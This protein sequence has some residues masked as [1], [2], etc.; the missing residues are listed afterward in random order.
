VII[1]AGPAGI[2]AAL[3]L[4]KAKQ[5][6]VLLLEKGP[7]AH[8]RHCP[9][10]KAG[11]IGCDPC[12]I[13]TGWGGAGAFSDGKL[14][15]TTDFGGFLGEH[16]DKEVVEA[17]IKNVDRTYLDYGAPAT[18][19]GDDKK[20]VTRLWKEAAS[21]GLS[22]VPA[23]IRH[24]GTENCLEIVKRMRTALQDRVDVLPRTVA[25]HIL[26]KDGRVIG[27]RT[28]DDT[29]Y[30]AKYVIAAPGREGAHWMCAEAERLGLELL[31]NPVDIGVRV[32]VPAVIMEHFTDTVYEAKLIY[33]SRTFDD[34][35][36]SFCMCP[37]G[38]VV[39]E[40][41]G[42]L[43]TVNGHSFRNQ[44]TN[45]TNFAL[46]VSKRFTHPFKQPLAYGKYIA[47]LANMLGGGVLVQRLG[48][49]QSGRRSTEKRMAKGLV[50]PTLKEATP[51][52][53]SLVLPYRH[54]IN[55]LEMLEAMDRIIPGVN[56]RNTLLYGVEVKFYSSRLQLNKALESQIH[57]L[58]AAGDGAGLTRGL[59]QAS[60]SGMYVGREILRREGMLKG[61]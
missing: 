51:G 20:A 29:D 10:K 53:L 54:L 23:R 37:H 27:V 58:F 34:Q 32:E 61:A 25:K 48:D 4:A 11:C 6:S 12:A 46:L 56:S 13:L 41:N 15:L 44:R 22:L 36:R 45:N 42:G 21:A 31:G 28:E 60:A 35:V 47:S 16:L 38:E 7:E 14:T 3:E 24:L 8:D 17:L 2:F 33:H 30:Y 1:G 26:A 49:L 57:N 5:L 18:L 50:Q 9:A 39:V 19:F 40:N 59:T 55:I 52:D 43:I